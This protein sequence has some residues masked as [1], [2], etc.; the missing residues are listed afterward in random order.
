M[1]QAGEDDRRMIGALL[2]I[3]REAALRQVVAG[4]AAADFDDVRPAHFTV[5]QHIPPEGIRLT[6]LAD[7]A[8]M[9]KQSMGYLVDD[10]EALGYVER[11][12][13][14]TDR[15]A[16][17]VRLTA[18]GRAVEDTVRKVIW[19]IEADWAA[20]LG[21]KEYQHLTRLLRALIALL[22]E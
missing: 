10:L 16:K 18:R 2:R 3:P 11:V 17:V 9:T 15:R 7:A 22:E 8:L 21:H 6:A 4:L 5:F 12:P 1:T 20:R 13:D 14:P 19:Q